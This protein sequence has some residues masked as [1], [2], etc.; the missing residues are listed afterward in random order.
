[1]NAFD[2]SSDPKPVMSPFVWCLVANVTRQSHPAGQAGQESFGTKHFAPGTKIYC[3]KP[4]WGD[5]MERL[6][7]MGI[8]KEGGAKPIKLISSTRWFVDWR[9]EKVHW[10]AIVKEM[11]RYRGTSWDGTDASR[12]EAEELATAMNRLVASRPLQVPGPSDASTPPG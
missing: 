3:F 10:P 1:M 6:Q 8:P 7:V 2:Q 12:R 5:G 11:G 9:V 4:G